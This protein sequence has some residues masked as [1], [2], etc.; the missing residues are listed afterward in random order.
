MDK[1]KH[2]L[3]FGGA[4]FRESLAHFTTLDNYGEFQFDG[5]FTGDGFAD[6]LLGL[7][8]RIDQDAPINKFT[9]D[10]TY[11]YRPSFKTTTGSFHG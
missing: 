10:S 5:D 2:A 4:F 7:P 9:N 11:S 1:G 8:T 6:F 3:R